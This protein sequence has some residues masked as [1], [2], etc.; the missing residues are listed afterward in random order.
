VADPLRGLKNGGRYKRRPEVEAQIDALLQ[1]PAEEVARRARD[2]GP[3]SQD[4]VATEV[5]LYFIRQKRTDQQQLALKS[6]Y[7]TLRHRIKSLHLGARRT[8]GQLTLEE[9]EERLLY[10]FE[11]LLCLDRQG[12]EERLDYFECVFNSGLFTLRINA[13]RDVKR[14]MPKSLE[15][16]ETEGQTEAS[17]NVEQALARFAGQSPDDKREE[18]YRLKLFEVINRLPEDLKRVIEMHDLR[19]IPIH[20]DLPGVTSVENILGIGEQTVRKRRKQA[21]L[22]LQKGLLGET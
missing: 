16:L 13:I 19:G 1:L 8:A 6:L 11:E 20:S 7:E 18:E 3:S 4:F 21:L 5:V 17:P 2:E 15:P 12:Y 9:V 22:A 10:R 14:K